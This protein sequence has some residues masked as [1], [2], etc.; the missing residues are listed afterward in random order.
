VDRLTWQTVTNPILTESIITNGAKGQWS[1]VV[2]NSDLFMRSVDG[3]RTLTLAELES[4]QWGTVPCSFEVS[5]VLDLDNQALL[6]YS[7]AI[8]FKN[9]LLHTTGPASSSNGVYH[10]GLVALNF[11]PTSSL[12]G[13]APAVW[14]SETWIGSGP[15]SQMQI[16]QMTVG[17]VT[18]A[19][20]AFAIVLNTTRSPATIEFWEIMDDN[21]AT[22]DNDGTNA[23]PIPWQFDSA[24][25]RFGVDKRDHKYMFLSNGEIW[26]DELVGAVTF[27]VLYKAD[28]FPAW[29]AWHS[30]QET[31]SSDSTISQPGFRPRMGLGEPSAVPL[32][33][34]TNRPM[35]NGFTFQ[36]R[37]IVV[38]HCVFLGGFYEA[39]TAL[40]TKFAR[41]IT[42]PPC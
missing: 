39:T 22:A 29:T 2:A 23:V 13:K 7:S 32:D 5:P 14:D 40:L 42:S 17:E 35:R 6:N 3:I 9:R 11:D 41:Q 31:Q 27:Q 15:T 4:N 33:R 25:L 16:M 28:Q 30:W 24:S 34:W 10:Q 18:G 38:G 12:R 19:E 21:A 37:H 36:I 26:V 20:R 1:T 8:V